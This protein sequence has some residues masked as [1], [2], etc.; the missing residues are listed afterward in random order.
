MK[1]TNIR[2]LPFCYTFESRIKTKGERISWFLIYPIYLLLFCYIFSFDFLY[3]FVGILS[4]MQMYE[5]G[6]LFNDIYTVKKEKN[7]TTRISG[8]LVWYKNKFKYLVVFKTITALLLPLVFLDLMFFSVM[9]TSLLFIL[10]FY[11]LHNNIRNRANVLT[12]FFLVS[13]R[14]TAPVFYFLDFQLFLLIIISFPLCRTLE[15]SC[16]KKY[17]I[18][19]SKLIVSSNVD[20]F[21]VKYYAFF[22]FIVFCFFGLGKALIIM[23]YFLT[24]R[25]LALLLSDSSYFKRN[26]HDSY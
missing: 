17:D 2:F 8:E 18:K 24:L 13:L 11:F 6:Y 5:V 25:A 14:Y 3:C 20:L 12:Y 26:K 7:P 9:T 21:R 15:H 22:T 10:F 23:S 16:K 1:F 19:L 4:T